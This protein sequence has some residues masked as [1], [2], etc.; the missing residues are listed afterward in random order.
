MRWFLQAWDY[1]VFQLTGRAVATCPLGYY[2]PWQSADIT[3]IGLDPTLF[4]PLARTGQVVAA[5]SALA[6]DE[7]GLP[8]ET[9]VVAGGNDFLL[10]TVG[11]A[12]AR[13]GIA[14]SQGGATSAF[15][16][17][18]DSPLEG[19]MIGWCI[20]SPIESALFNIGGPISTGGTALDW[21]LQSLLRSPLDYGAAL[22][23]A[24]V[25]PAG[26]D[27]LLF[28]PYLTGEEVTMGPETR[29]AFL[30]LSLAHKTAHL[31][32]AVLEGVALAG[33]SILESLVQAGG[34]VEEIVTYG[35]QARSDLWNQIKANVWN[36]PL[37]TPKVTHVGCLG[38]AAIA[39]VGIGQYRSLN[40]AS[41]HMAQPGE[42]YLPDPDQVSVYNA[43]HR[44]FQQIH[45]RTRDLFTGLGEQFKAGQP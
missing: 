31:I 13:K 16:L 30:G 44:V 42:C 35:G 4:P 41:Q 17:C 20:P 11:V 19:E 32:R 33:R 34:C 15:T 21:L 2:A 36:R 37:R 25:A 29:G 3:S 8:S 22:A 9:P 45:P 43:A 10:G 1:I 38:A 26:A 12:G 27:G 23:H 24:A 7:T 18:W 14:Q 39:A 6:S 28:F 5:L 40:V